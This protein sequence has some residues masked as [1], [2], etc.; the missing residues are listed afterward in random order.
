MAATSSPRSVALRLGMN[1]DLRHAILPPEFE[2]IC[3][4][5]PCK[6]WMLEVIK[7]RWSML[8][9]LNEL[10]RAKEANLE[11]LKDPTKVDPA[12]RVACPQLPPRPRP[13]LDLP[14]PTHVFLL[15]RLELARTRALP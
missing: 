2:D 1:D 13:C 12:L 6:Y 9:D 8:Q 10:S 3:C 11:H 7:A 5:T 15:S 14:L 4:T